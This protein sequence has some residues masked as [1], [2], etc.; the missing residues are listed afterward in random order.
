MTE[1]EKT[2]KSLKADLAASN[3]EA[4]RY[5]N[6]LGTLRSRVKELTNH[7]CGLEYQLGTIRQ[8]LSLS[9]N[10]KAK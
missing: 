10:G 4:Q 3:E 5:L 7:I 2:I 6:E 9:F 8:V 1:A